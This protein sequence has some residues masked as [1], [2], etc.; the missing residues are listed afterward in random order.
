[1]RAVSFILAFALVAAG[2]STAGSAENDLPGIGT[3]SYN[4]APIVADANGVAAR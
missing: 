2:S 4:G 3:F 1:M